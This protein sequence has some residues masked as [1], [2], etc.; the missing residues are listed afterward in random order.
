MKKK[1]NTPKRKIAFSDRTVDGSQTTQGGV[2]IFLSTS[3]IEPD[4]TVIMMQWPPNDGPQVTMGEPG[5][6]QKHLNTI[7]AWS[8][9]ADAEWLDD[10]TECRKRELE[11]FITIINHHGIGEAL[12]QFSSIASDFKKKPMKG[13]DILKRFAENPNKEQVAKEMR[14]SKRQV[15][16]TIN[17]L[18]NTYGNITIF[19]PKKNGPP[20]GG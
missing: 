6:G 7:E 10:K 13:L 11:L 14:V 16:R 20:I 18:Y 8:P 15:Q 1:A 4:G 3:H 17:R 9:F 5:F 12:D 19:P 2:A